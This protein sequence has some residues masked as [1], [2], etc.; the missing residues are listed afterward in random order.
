[1]GHWQIIILGTVLIFLDVLNIIVLFAETTWKNGQLISIL[2][3]FI[4]SS[5]G[6]LILY[7]TSKYMDSKPK[8]GL[9]ISFYIMIPIVCIL[10]ILGNI[11]AGYQ[12][13]I[14][15]HGGY[16]EWL[17]GLLGAMY[18][19][20]GCGKVGLFGAEVIFAIKLLE[21]SLLNTSYLGLLCLRETSS[22]PRS[23]TNSTFTHINDPI[24]PIYN[25]LRRTQHY[26]DA[27]LGKTI[28]MINTFL[29]FF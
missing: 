5:M 12:I 29:P 2:D 10:G 8:R 27:N 28:I 11:Y 20:Y 24:S 14:H 13:K 18:A 23:N 7:L 22:A 15:T 17:G 21:E 25:N 9:I 19:I 16:F 6:G 26:V 1:M 4:R 3:C